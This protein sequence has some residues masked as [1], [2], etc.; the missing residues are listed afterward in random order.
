MSSDLIKQCRQRFP[1]AWWFED[2]C[3]IMRIE[4][5]G[6]SFNMVVAHEGT[7][8]LYWGGFAHIRAKTAMLLQRSELPSMPRRTLLEAVH[9]MD[10]ARIYAQQEMLHV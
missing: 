5:V 3:S 2:K 7:I 6:D 10:S 1:K 9:D 8:R 4:A